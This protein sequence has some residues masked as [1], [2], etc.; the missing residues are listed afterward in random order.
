MMA[1]LHTGGRSAQVRATEWYEC[2]A[3][4]GGA[5]HG[6]FGTQERLER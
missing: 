3:G 2:E 1:R 6:G 5:L 4:C